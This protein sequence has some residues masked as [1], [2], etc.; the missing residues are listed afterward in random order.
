MIHFG[1]L[2]AAL[3]G[4][5]VALGAF[6]AHGLRDRVSEDLLEIY[7]TSTHYLVIH[8]I[9]LILFHLSGVQKRWPGFCF[10]AGIAIFSGS[11]Y[12]ILLTGIR[13]LGAITPI[14]GV[15]LMAGWAGFAFL[16]RFRDGKSSF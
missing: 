13:A 11:L 16:W 1:R 15:L 14:G 5:G 10:L 6:G 2:G 8:A 12:G 9:A 3:A 7:K 4:I